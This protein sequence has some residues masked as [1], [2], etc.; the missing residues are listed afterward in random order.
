MVNLYIS[1]DFAHLSRL[2]FP[3]SRN[4]E[5]NASFVNGKYIFGHDMWLIFAIPSSPRKRASLENVLKT[6]PIRMDSSIFAFYNAG[7]GKFYI[8][9]YILSKSIE[10]IY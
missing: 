10:I 1:Q 2:L 9:F 6:S 4:I 5:T 3:E 7:H 8:F